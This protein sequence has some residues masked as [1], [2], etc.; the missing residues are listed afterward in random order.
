MSDIIAICG[1]SCCECEG[2]Q[3]TQANDLAWKERIVAKWREEYHNDQMTVEAVTCDG[4]TTLNGRL[5]GYCPHCEIRKCGVER[6]L[7]NCAACP[8]YACEK[9]EKFFLMAPAARQNLEAL[10]PS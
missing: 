5:G 3:A 1:L 7:D 6:Q 9:L 10:R 2:Y 4:C 8:D